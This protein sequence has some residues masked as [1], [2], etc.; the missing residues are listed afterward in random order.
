M[1]DP[2]KPTRT[3]N[4]STN[5]KE[6]SLTKKITIALVVI[7]ILSLLF[8]AYTIFGGGGEEDENSFL[9]T[10]SESSSVIS[11]SSEE[12]SSSESSSESESS[13][14]SES[15]SAESSE[16]QD[17]SSESEEA[18]SGDWDP[19]GTEQSGEHTTNYS[20]G[21]QDRIEIKRASSVATGI[22]E[23]D[24]IE[25]WVGNAGDQQVETTVSNTAQTVTYRVILRW[26]DNQ[27]WQPVQVE[28][29]S[30][31]PYN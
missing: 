20:E 22:S 17:E 13:E 2:N 4:R 6:Q 19:V 26:V 15:S 5:S 25:W 14:S 12:E 27:G 9:D 28:E 7:L 30:N 21:S 18:V 1:K 24:I 11:E 10:S 29:L 8:L 23:G 3:N 31:N 16:E